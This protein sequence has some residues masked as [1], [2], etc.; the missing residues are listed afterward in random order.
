[1]HDQKLYLKSRINKSLEGNKTKALLTTHRSQISILGCGWSGLPLAQS[2]VQQGYEVIGSTTTPEK[3]AVIEAIGARSLVWAVSDHWE[4]TAAQR[5]FFDAD[6]L[7]VTLPPP[8]KAGCDGYARDVHA[9]IAAA[10]KETGT[11]HTILFSSTSVYPDEPAQYTEGEAQRLISRHTGIAM[12]DL[13]DV[14]L[15]AELAQLTILRLG[16]LFGPGREPGDFVIRAGEV[17]DPAQVVNMTHLDDIIGAVHFAMKRDA[18][19]E[20]Y[21]V[22]AP[23]HP[24]R[25]DFYRQALINLNAA[26]RVSIPRFDAEE[27]HQRKVLSHR[28]CAHGYE[29]KHPD[30]LEVLQQMR[31]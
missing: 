9:A 24:F 31:Q 27:Q 3:V 16:G 8:K 11:R 1:M 21:N 30:P 10:A 23:E 6:V 13:E 4:M 2:L 5:A 26:H 19:N 7:V 20:V 12:K 15:D 14:Y 22:V 25:G 18:G 17:R 28:I 29:F